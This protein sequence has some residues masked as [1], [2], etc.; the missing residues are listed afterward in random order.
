V[1]VVIRSSPIGVIVLTSADF[2]QKIVGMTGDQKQTS[3]AARITPIGK[4]AKKH[5]NVSSVG[6][7]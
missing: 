6:I 3:S 2:V 1:S 7:L 4:A 5:S